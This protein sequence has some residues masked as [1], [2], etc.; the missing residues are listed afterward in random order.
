MTHGQKNCEI[1]SKYTRRQDMGH[2]KKIKLLTTYR[3]LFVG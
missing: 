1:C 2:E 3:S